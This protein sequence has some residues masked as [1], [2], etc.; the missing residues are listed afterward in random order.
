MTGLYSKVT[1]YQRTVMSLSIIGV[2]YIGRIIPKM[3]CSVAVSRA[4]IRRQRSAGLN[5]KDQRGLVILT[6][7]IDIRIVS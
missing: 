6:G 2:I 4:D 7:S 1:G 5:V 3:Y